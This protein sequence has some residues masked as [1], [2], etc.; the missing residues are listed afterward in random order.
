MKYVWLIAFLLLILIGFEAAANFVSAVIVG[1]MIL[2]L[3]T[4]VF[5]AIS[6]VVVMI[7]LFILM[8]SA[9]RRDRRE[10]GIMKGLGYT[11]RE[12]MFQLACRIVPSAVFSVIIGTIIGVT[13][14]DL[15]TSIIGIVKVN[16]PQVIVLDIVMLIFCFVCAYVGARKIKT[17]SVYELMTE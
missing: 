1:G 12:L 2:L 15:L 14:T 13:M 17:I 3:V 7:I 10:F 8:E 6:A 11:S 9:I 16:I 4:A 5:M